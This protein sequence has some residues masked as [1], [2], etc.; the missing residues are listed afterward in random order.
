M[1][2]LALHIEK[3]RPASDCEMKINSVLTETITV[4]SNSDLSFQDCLPEDV[5][6]TALRV[7]GKSIFQY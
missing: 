3:L 1:E 4:T 2:G 7:I 5:R 6:V